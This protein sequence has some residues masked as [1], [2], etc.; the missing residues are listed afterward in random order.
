M[1]YWHWRSLSIP[2]DSTGAQQI[3]AK[4]MVISNPLKQYQTH[5]NTCNITKW[6]TISTHFY[7]SSDGTKTFQCAYLFTYRH[8]GVIILYCGDEL[9]TFVIILDNGHVNNSKCS[10]IPNSIHHISRC[11]YHEICVREILII[12]FPWLNV[13][14]RGTIQFR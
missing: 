5:T 12:S 14:K 1:L 9:W 7:H 11:I 10:K 3:T 6:A 4:W 8:I 2:S 13:M